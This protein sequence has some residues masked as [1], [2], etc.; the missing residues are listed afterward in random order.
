MGFFRGLTFQ[1]LT[2]P[3]PYPPRVTRG[4]F[5]LWWCSHWW[6]SISASFSLRYHVKWWRNHWDMLETVNLLYLS[7]FSTI[8]HD[9]RVKMIQRECGIPNKAIPVTR[10]HGSGFPVGNQICTLTPTPQPRGTDPYGL[11]IP[12]HYWHAEE[13]EMVQN[14]GR[15]CSLFHSP[16]LMLA[17]GGT[18]ALPW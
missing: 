11:P 13:T 1:T 10:G 7:Y 17:L 16:T 8:L 6:E 14:A 2:Y 15:H 3:Y 4:Y 12:M 18:H 9:L 5:A